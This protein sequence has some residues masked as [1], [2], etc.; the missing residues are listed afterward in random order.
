[1]NRL[2]IAQRVAE[3]TTSASFIREM[4]ERGRR[5]K[6][7]FG[8]ANVYDFSLGNPN[9]RPPQAFFDALRAVA[10]EI[11]P[12]RHRYMPNPGF[13][14]AR[15]AV[16]A[17][18]S[19]EYKLDIDT[20]GVQ[21]V[22]RDAWANRSSLRVVVDLNAVPPLGVD[23]IEVMDAGAD[24]HGAKVFGALGIGNFKMK[25]HKRCVTKL[26]ERNDLVLDAET[27]GDVAR[28]LLQSAPAP[29]SVP[30]PG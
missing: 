6:A 22:A 25:V 24:R 5:L 15:A 11:E 9:A 30:P 7:E 21:L 17:F 20:A 27:I 8:E 28:E 23:G 4:F 26:F 3:A 2:P 13:D 18:L 10:G 14:E 19:R 29:P 1:M 12:A 16:A